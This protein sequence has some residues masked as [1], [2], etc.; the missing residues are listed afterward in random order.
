MGGK[1]PDLSIVDNNIEIAKISKKGNQ[2][3]VR[4][5][6]VLRLM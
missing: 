1:S 4:E 2:V 3:K 5:Q 6:R